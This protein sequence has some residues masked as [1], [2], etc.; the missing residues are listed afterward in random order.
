MSKEAVKI[1]KK[2]R[3][4]LTLIPSQAMLIKPIL[5][6]L[7]MG[8]ELIGKHNTCLNMS[9]AKDKVYLDLLQDIYTKHYTLLDVKSDKYQLTISKAQAVVLWELGQIY[10]SIVYCHP[11]MNNIMFLLHQKLS[12]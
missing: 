11:V 4:T 10:E 8:L 6:G 5:E 9:N 3:I 12:Q 1:N 2:G 7:I